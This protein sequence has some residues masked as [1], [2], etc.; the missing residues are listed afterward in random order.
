LSTNMQEQA[1]VADAIEAADVASSPNMLRLG[2]RGSALAL[3]QARIVQNLLSDAAP[4]IQ[5]VIRI[6]QSLG[7]RVRDQ[8]LAALNAQGIFTQAIEEALRGGHV[9]AAV[10][11][12]KDLPST[13]PTD[14]CIVA[15]PER[16]DPRDCLVTRDGLSL[17]ALPEGATVG[18]GSPR[19][20]AQ[21]RRLRPDLRFHPIRGNVDTRRN[22][23]L[24]GRLDA[25]IL[26]AAGLDRLGL[27]D[28]HAYPLSP[29]QCLPQAG[30]GALAIEVRSDDV[31]TAAILAGINHK[32]S[33]ACLAAERAVLAHLSAGCQAPAAA[34]AVINEDGTLY[35]RA[36]VASLDGIGTIEASHSGTLDQAA[37]IGAVV[38]ERLRA[39]GADVLLAKARGLD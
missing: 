37:E 36:G 39:Q 35:L 19:R 5:M 23:A 18:T 15:I 28:G 20:V 2:T 12:A 22:A 1:A 8:P 24:E 29:D 34:F 32:L 30:Q 16:A 26:A 9:D 38:A 3:I 21:L 4:S 33:A 25:V 17:A 6:V 11:S 13:L 27:L 14:M 31:V 7:D 10:H